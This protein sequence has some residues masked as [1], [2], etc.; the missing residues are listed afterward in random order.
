MCELTSRCMKKRKPEDGFQQYV[1]GAKARAGASPGW[2]GGR[3]EEQIHTLRL[4]VKKSWALR[5][6]ARETGR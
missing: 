6:P 3:R 4:Q 2:A 5:R 1:A